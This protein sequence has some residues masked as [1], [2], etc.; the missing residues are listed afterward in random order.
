VL[1]G[2]QDGQTDQNNQQNPAANRLPAA[3]K[4]IHHKLLAEVMAAQARESV[5]LQAQLQPAKP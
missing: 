5:R 3:S 2:R 4:W 1:R